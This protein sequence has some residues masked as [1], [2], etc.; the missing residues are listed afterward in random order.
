MSVVGVMQS[1]A[2]KQKCYASR[3]KV[4]SRR[5]ECLF[6]LI[7]LTFWK[8]NTTDN[9]EEILSS[10]AVAQTGCYSHS[11]EGFLLCPTS[12]FL[13]FSNYLS[14]IHVCTDSC[15]VTQQAKM[16]KCIY[17]LCTWMSLT[18]NVFHFSLTDIHPYE[19]QHEQNACSLKKRLNK[20][21][22]SI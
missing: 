17:K 21:N 15:A 9:K 14:N 12:S 22:K 1:N 13:F 8:L 5:W 6:S 2:Q 4:T 11:I 3:T 16:H 18:Q 19:R 7:M 10:S 20:K